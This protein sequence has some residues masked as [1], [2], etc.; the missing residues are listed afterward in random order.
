MLL[1]LRPAGLR[2]CSCHHVVVVV[3]VLV[4]ALS[5]AE[6]RLHQ[7]RAT[8]EGHRRLSQQHVKSLRTQNL[9]PRLW[10]KNCEMH[11]SAMPGLLEGRR[12]A[13]TSARAC[14][15]CQVACRIRW[16]PLWNREAWG[17]IYK[18]PW[19]FPWCRPK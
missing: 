1:A 17:K 19:F 7:G 12:I 5:R 6:L 9:Q 11:R 15:K 10:N 2:Q 13:L 8:A 3:Q 18:W 16:L 4:L 14:H